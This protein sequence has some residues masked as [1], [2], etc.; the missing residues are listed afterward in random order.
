MLANFNDIVFSIFDN[1][2]ADFENVFS[3]FDNVFFEVRQRVLEH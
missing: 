2:L 1:V 3:K